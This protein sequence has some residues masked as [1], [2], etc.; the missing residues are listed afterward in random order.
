MRNL[1]NKLG[2]CSFALGLAIA[3]LAF[4]GNE[5]LERTFQTPPAAARPWVYW[6]WLNSNVTREGITRDL[7]EMHRQGIQG[8]LI[9]NAGG[10]DTPAGPKFLSPEWNA[11]F[12]FALSELSRLGMEA[13]VNLC[14][15]WDAG[16]PWIPA[17]AAN[18]KLTYSETQ[19]DAPGA[20]M[21]ELPLPPTLDNFY[22]DVAVLAI[23][24][25]GTKPVQ[26]A[27]I[28]ACP[29]VG[30]YCDEKNWPPA[31][32]ADGDPNTVWRSAHA[33]APAPPAW[34]DFIYSEPLA[35]S[36]IYLIGA[37]D[38]GPQQCALQTSDDGV[39][40]TTL[41]VTWTMAKGESK[42]VEFPE[43]KAKVFRLVI[44]SSH[45]PDVRLAEMQIL[46]KGDEPAVRPG[47]KWWQFKSGNRGFWDWPKAG[48]AV[49]EEEYPQDGTADCQSKEVVDLTSKMDK[50]GKL[51][52]QVPEG[53]WTILR[54]GY[55]LVGQRT[56]CSSGGSANVIGYEAD[57]LDPLGIETHFKHCGE[58]LLAAAG[59]YAGKT[60]K[61]LHIDS[62]EVGADI[63]GQ[64]PTWSAK[65]LEE[66]RTR[67]GYDPLPYLPAMARRIVDNREKTDRFL[68]DI[69]MTI[70]DLMCDCFFKR[71]ADLA[72]G[73]GV[74]MQCE[75]GY[76]TYPHPQ[77]DG[78]RAAGQGDVTM[79]EFWYGTDIMSQFYPFCN[80]IRSVA[81]PAHIYGK[82]IIQAES[83]TAWSH[84]LEYPSALKP[85][86]DEAF[87][88]GLNRIVF[89]Q[90]TH[91]PNDDMPGYQ[92]GA[93]THIDR[94]LTWWNMSQPFLTYLTRCQY[95]LQSGRF[96]A[97]VC[98]LNAEG[99]SHYV[100][101]KK[102]LKPALPPGYNF[103]CI[104]ADVL[105]NRMTRQGWNQLVL[106]DG[107]EYIRLMLLPVGRHHVAQ[108]AEEN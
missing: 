5:D 101:S 4:A 62:Y 106:P 58:P 31:D 98:Y 8:V 108:S 87:C 10:G 69:R 17:E 74:S 104:N 20:G 6:W 59:E 88:D 96:H 77:F 97:D 83:F 42:R 60:L 40:F 61:Y 35:A 94:H 84:F 75:T 50:D 48:P 95:I 79:G 21:T 93:G 12:E 67:R 56:R 28:R 73:H 3:G 16:G 85:L 53:R 24:E 22:H 90:W 45:A 14:D 68:W 91:Q 65:F 33:P 51:S 36:A 30:G 72:H 25:K 55:T 103:D 9:F 18:K 11:L 38:A 37:K 39:N 71:F 92:Y 34:I 49:M 63:Q 78:L 29:T 44:Q 19:I 57:M 89:H 102:Y 86:G 1:K 107:M 32:T 46:R 99:S 105:L 23:R 76:G 15:G 82:K 100:P 47:I 64:Q 52:W 66:F 43:V 80:V 41:P 54:F 26:P 70:S 13:G 7:E 81:S 2:W 27:E